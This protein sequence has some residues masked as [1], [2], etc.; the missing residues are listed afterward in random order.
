MWENISFWEYFIEELK[1][2]PTPLSQDLVQVHVIP[3]S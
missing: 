3:A 2:Q 1:P